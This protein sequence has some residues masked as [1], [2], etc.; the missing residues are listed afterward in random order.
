MITSTGN[1][2]IRRL[3]QLRKKAKERDAQD[4]FLVEGIKMFREIP[5][6][7]LKEV[8]ASESFIKSALGKSALEDCRAE[9]QVVSDEVFQAIS[10]TRTPQGILALAGQLH[11]RPEDLLGRAGGQT[12]AER[13]PL[14]VILENLQDPGNLGTIL[15]TAEGAGVT[16]I[17]LGRGS[18]DVYNPKVT[19]STMG[20]I[21]RLPFYYT[22]DLAASMRRLRS[23]GILIYAAHLKGD[24]DYDQVDCR[25]ACAFLIGNESR[26]LSDSAAA[27]ADRL[28]RIPMCGNV[29]SLNA[30]VASAILMYEAG[31][32]R[33]REKT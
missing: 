2:R 3:V 14:L 6:T 19:R 24:R 1:S 5:D 11:Y 33:R 25:C 8:Y 28:I 31:R 17:L 16:G 22:E 27:E 23:E 32:Q 10:D 9:I 26:G 7:L 13:K 4:V 21:F 18:A 15:R 12:E 29:E 30:G 20:S